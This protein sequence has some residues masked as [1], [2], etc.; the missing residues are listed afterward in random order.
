[1]GKSN[2]KYLNKSLNPE[3]IK[4]IKSIVSNKKRN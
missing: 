2:Y 3:S 4:F 1:M